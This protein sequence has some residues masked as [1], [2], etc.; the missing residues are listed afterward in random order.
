[1]DLLD[2]GLRV[3]KTFVYF[4][5][6]LKLRFWKEKSFLMIW[7]LWCD[8]LNWMIISWWLIVLCVELFVCEINTIQI[9]LGSE[10]CVGNWFYCWKTNLWMA[11]VG[12]TKIICF[13]ANYYFQV[14]GCVRIWAIK[15]VTFLGF[16]GE[17][18]LMNI[19]R[20]IHWR[21]TVLGFTREVFLMDYRRG[22]HWQWGHTP[23]FN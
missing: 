4:K 6:L 18:F 2:Y 14:M 11:I 1:M 5:W 13:D 3:S 21:V 10:W 16:T 7:G 19:R 15:I 8:I 22:I 23:S 9:L 20:G 17:V 12:L